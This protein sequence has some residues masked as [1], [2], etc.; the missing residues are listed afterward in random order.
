MPEQPKFIAKDKNEEIW[1]I[2]LPTENNPE[3]WTANRSYFKYEYNTLNDI[4]YNLGIKWKKPLKIR[5]HETTGA[6]LKTW[7]PNAKT[8]YSLE[9]SREGLSEKAKNNLEKLQEALDSRGYYAA[10]LH[11]GNYVYTDDEGWD[12]WY[13]IDAIMGVVSG[14]TSSPEDI[15]S[16]TNIK[17]IKTSKEALE[18]EINILS[19]LIKK[20]FVN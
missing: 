2:K 16:K 11:R 8:L 14:S 6:I 9:N 10:D 20:L 15:L 19:Q 3:E 12:S 5:L 17:L 7:V 1:V 4:Y 13:I 18:K